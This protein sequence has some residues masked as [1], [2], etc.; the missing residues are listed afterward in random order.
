MAE[1]KIS[2]KTLK[3]SFFNW[4]FFNGCSQQAESMLGMAF[5]QAMAPVVEELYDTK[6]DRAAALTRHITLFNTEAQV[7]SIC[8]GIVCG[9]EEANAN[10]NCTPE[11]IESVKVA[12]IGPTSAIGDSLWVATI[13][14]IL[15]TISL[16]LSQANP[17]MAWLGPVV[18][19]IVYPFGTMALSWWLFK[20]GYKSGLEGMQTMM[21]TGK[22]DYLTDAMSVLGLIVVGA[23]TASFV[24]CTIPLQIVKDV[25]NAETGE[26]L[27][28]QVLFNADSMLNAIFPKIVPLALTLLVYFLYAKKKWSPM[29]LM[30][31]ILV[32]AVALTGLGYFTG[33]YA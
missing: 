32:L 16:S 15:L 8:N 31:L 24:S 13:I 2:D 7:G 14:P 26:V 3:K 18:Y 9:L 11:V 22:L 23:L 10:G 12:L 28:N 27:A 17:A 1:K 6:E 29:K 21:S 19:M 5:G 20:K 30:G 33:F 25:F 4:F